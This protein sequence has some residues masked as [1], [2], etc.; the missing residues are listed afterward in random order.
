MPVNGQSRALPANPQINL[1]ASG[2]GQGCLRLLEVRGSSAD[3]AM[4]GPMAVLKSRFGSKPCQAEDGPRHS[5]LADLLRVELGQEYGP[6]GA[7]RERLEVGL[8]ETRLTILVDDRSL[9]GDPQRLPYD[10]VSGLMDG[11]VA[12]RQQCGA[13]DQLTPSS[14]IGGGSAWLR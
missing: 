4:R 13:D 12:N 14:T 2:V 9:A 1:G 6:V 8:N 11:G 10:E 3:D 5:R 7:G